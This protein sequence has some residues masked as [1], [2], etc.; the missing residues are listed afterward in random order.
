MLKRKMVN[1]RR[2]SVA[3]KAMLAKRYEA[4]AAINEVHRAA[5]AATSTAFSNAAI[6]EAASMIRAYRQ[7]FLSSKK[8]GS[9][10]RGRGKK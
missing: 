6:E 10:V 8:T 2:L 9:G 5:L 7:R 3:E 1:P 4:E